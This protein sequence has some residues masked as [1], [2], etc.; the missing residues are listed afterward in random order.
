MSFSSQVKNELAKIEY[1]NN[2]CKK[3][4]LY[5][6]ALFAKS[7][8]FKNFILQSE[9]ENI[10]ILF[11]RLV[12]ECCN[13]DTVVKISPSGKTFTILL[14]KNS[15]RKLMNYFGHLNTETSLKINFANFDCPSCQRAFVAGAFLSCGTVSS[16]E[17][18]YHLEL[19]IPYFNLT[20]SFITLLREL[21]LSPKL[22]KRG[23]YNIVYFKESEAIEDCLYIMGAA[24]SM[25]EM[26]NIE[27][28]KDL[29]NNAN[30]KAN[31]E[32]ANIEKMVKAASP[33]ISAILK[34]KEKKGLDFLSAPLKEMAEIRLENPDLS[35]QELA[36]MF[37]PPLSKSGANHRLKRIIDIADNLE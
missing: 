29:R 23:G 19:A 35:L 36:E 4:L 13:I 27:I 31:C 14:A 37:N 34:I 30:R 6:M 12:K 33:Q 5:G 7:F 18:N 11:K 15:A 17:K 3:S 32:T 25:F 8:S 24:S 26:M 22:S 21:E 9:N 20:K 16:P 28:V 2:C 1:D 10:I